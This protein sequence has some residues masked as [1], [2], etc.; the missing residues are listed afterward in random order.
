MLYQ[1]PEETILLIVLILL[2]GSI[3][4]RKKPNYFESLNLD[5]DVNDEIKNKLK[6]IGL[7]STVI[8][9]I[10]YEMIE[11][12]LN[13]TNWFANDDQFVK[14]ELKLTEVNI[15]NSMMRIANVNVFKMDLLP[16]IS[17]ALTI[18]TLVWNFL[19]KISVSDGL[20][21][22]SIVAILSCL[23]FV[24]AAFEHYYTKYQFIK[25]AL[26]RLELNQI[27]KTCLEL[28]LKK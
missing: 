12:A 21:Q 4:L 6:N 25:L 15:S 20:T 14:K 13:K 18:T 28:R 5:L 1:Y 19:S 10:F 17:V 2:V 24:V 27:K 7:Q 23:V 3:F 26:I 22:F 11:N 16:F 9:G 8:S